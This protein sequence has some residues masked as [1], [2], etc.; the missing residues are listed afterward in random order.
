MS[1]Y[2]FKQWKILS[3]CFTDRPFLYLYLY[4]A[5]FEM[6]KEAVVC[7]SLLENVQDFEPSVLIYLELIKSLLY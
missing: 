4:N 6:R 1:N 2:I 3:V 7:N 5:P